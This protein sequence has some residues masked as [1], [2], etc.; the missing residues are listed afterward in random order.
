MDWQPIIRA[1]WERDIELAVIDPDGS[2]QALPFPCRRTFGGWLDAKTRVWVD[3]EPTHWREWPT[4]EAKQSAA[5]ANIPAPVV[6]GNRPKYGGTRL[7]LI[8]LIV[9]AAG[10]LLGPFK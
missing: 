1:P 2:M 10:A 6:A 3:L 8:V 7:I 9:A 5:P 4:P